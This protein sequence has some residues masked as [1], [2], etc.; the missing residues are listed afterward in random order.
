MFLCC[1]KVFVLRVM[2]QQS[3]CSSSGAVSDVNSIGKE[4]QNW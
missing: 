1:F 3:P 4:I 2:D